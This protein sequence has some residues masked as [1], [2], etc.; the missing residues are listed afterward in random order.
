MHVQAAIASTLQQWLSSHPA[1]AWMVDHPL[2]ALFLGLL[3]LFLL[4]SLL[5]AITRLMEQIWIAILAMPLK[6]LRWLFA[7]ALQPLKGLDLLNRQPPVSKDK[8]LAEILSRLDA[9]RQEEAALMTEMKAILVTPPAQKPKV[10]TVVEQP[11]LP[12]AQKGVV[13]P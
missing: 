2:P 9:L 12:L 4:W 7:G 1:I 13:N 8:R 11:A 10:L 3:L 5:G 6:S